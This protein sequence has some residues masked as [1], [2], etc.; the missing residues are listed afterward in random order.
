MEPD[1]QGK[2]GLTELNNPDRQKNVVFQSKWFS[3]H[4]TPNTSSTSSDPYYVLDRLDS[5]TIIPSSPSGRLLMQEQHR[6]H[7][8]RDSW[9]FPMGSIDAGKSPEQ[10]AKR[11]LAEKT[12]LTCDAWNKLAATIRYL[13]CQRNKPTF[14]W[15]MSLMS[16]WAKRKWHCRKGSQHFRLLMCRRSVRSLPQLRL[17]MA[18]LWPHSRSG[19]LLPFRSLR[20]KQRKRTWPMEAMRLQNVSTASQSI[21]KMKLLIRLFRIPILIEI[22]DVRIASTK[23]VQT[24]ARNHVKCKKVNHDPLTF[25]ASTYLLQSSPSCVR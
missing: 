16:S 8:G 9:E 23:A 4:A 6:A 15:R 2:V 22:K 18:S 5:A 7:T 3:I 1:A 10:A 25:R 14:L 24:S 12:G 11:E 21:G 13:D 20:R 17:S 19:N